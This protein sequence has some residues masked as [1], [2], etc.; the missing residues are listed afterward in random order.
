MGGRGR[1]LDVTGWRDTAKTGFAGGSHCDFGRLGAAKPD[2]SF[3]RALVMAAPYEVNG[4]VYVGDKLDNDL[5]PAKAARLRPAFIRGGPW[6]YIWEHHPDMSDAV[7][8]RMTTLE[9]LPPLV[10]EV[11]RPER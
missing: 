6:G 9:E 10:A 3:F 8:W 4:I 5:K 1:Q 11:N 7:D 2:Q